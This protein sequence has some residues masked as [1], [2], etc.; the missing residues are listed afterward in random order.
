MLVGEF[1]GRGIPLELFA[2][3]AA[4]PRQFTDPAA[5]HLATRRNA[6]LFDFSFM[7]CFEIAGPGALPFLERIQTRRIA[8]LAPGR[9]AYTLLLRNDGTVLV[10]ATVWRHERC[11]WLFTGRRSDRH[12]LAE[13]ARGFPASLRDRSGEFA[14]IALQGPASLRLLAA[15]LGAAPALPYFGFRAAR[16]FGRKAWIG[17]LG[18]TGE[19][20]VEILV[21]ERDGP[22]VW[23]RLRE[24]GARECGFRAADS[25]RIE[26]GYILFCNELRA[27]V[28]PAELGMERL[29]DSP[30]EFVGAGRSA[31][32]RRRLVGVRLLGGPL[33]AGRTARVEVTSECES[34]LF[35]PLA[36]GF[37]GSD[38]AHPGSL[39]VLEDGRV[40]RIARLPFF[41]PPR[42]VPRRP[43]A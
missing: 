9:I 43:F 14:V 19:L 7:G 28:T 2:D 36:L 5:E 6:G 40:G 13:A 37:A 11:W 24:S 39:A 12:Y 23:N 4:I 38:D 17:R 31:P 30:G 1:V 35:G 25:L 42:A 27:P 8:A 16:L 20:G 3:G 22:E 18:Y 41:D 33:R 21:A 15:A 29:V 32:A 34:P 26:A 10:D